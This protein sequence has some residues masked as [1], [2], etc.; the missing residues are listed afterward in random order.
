[1][2]MPQLNVFDTVI[3]EQRSL[4]VEANPA[5]RPL[6]RSLTPAWLELPR[7]DIPTQPAVVNHPK[8]IAVTPLGAVLPK[9]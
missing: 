8:F 2:S 3:P 6:S 4:I 5:S 1:M 7:K 9:P